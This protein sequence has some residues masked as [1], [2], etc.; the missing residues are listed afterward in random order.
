MKTKIKK[1]RQERPVFG[2]QVARSVLERHL[3]I[4]RVVFV[5]AA[6][7]GMQ[8][9]EIGAVHPRFRNRFVLILILRNNTLMINHHSMSCG[10]MQ[11]AKKTSTSE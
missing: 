9:E 3:H 7:L 8:H 2:G 10:E 4:E 5:V 1:Y 6:V 11:R